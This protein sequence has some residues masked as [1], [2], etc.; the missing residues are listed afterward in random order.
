MDRRAYTVRIPADEAADLEAVAAAEG[1][2]V[3]EEIRLAIADR[4][5]AKRKDKAFRARLRALIE[6]NQ[7]VLERLADGPCWQP[8]ARSECKHAKT[9]IPIKRTGPAAATAVL[10]LRASRS[11]R[12]RGFRRRPVSRATIAFRMAVALTRL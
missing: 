11:P 12:P 4:V 3:S 5:A 2:S 8:A 9:T 1:L 6:Q 7:R 10:L